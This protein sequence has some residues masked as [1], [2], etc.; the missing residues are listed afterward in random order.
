MNIPYVENLGSE[1]W[2]RY[3]VSDG[4]RFWTGNSW[5]DQPRDARLFLQEEEAEM[6]CGQLPSTR[7][8]KTSISLSV[9]THKDYD[10]NAIRQFLEDNISG[11][12]TNEEYEVVAEVNL[13][14]LTEI[15]DG[16]SESN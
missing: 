9:K 1:K 13:E 14:E 8:F 5:S 6:A 16:L 12:F 15:D 4:Q 2:Q 10:L 11:L 7:Q 3:R